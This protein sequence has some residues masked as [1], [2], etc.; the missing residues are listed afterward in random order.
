MAG[1]GGAR[2]RAVVAA[3]HVGTIVS[4]GQTACAKAATV[5]GR[6]NSAP[7]ACRQQA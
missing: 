1:S 5:G 2:A 7:C 4:R 6:P 3:G